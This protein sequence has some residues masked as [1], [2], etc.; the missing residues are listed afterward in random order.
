MERKYQPPP[1]TKVT[2]LISQK[3]EEEKEP[4]IP[5]PNKIYIKD[6]VQPRGGLHM[7]RYAEQI[8]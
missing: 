4:A 1:I 3:K 2:F 8:F 6:E 5:I 7:C